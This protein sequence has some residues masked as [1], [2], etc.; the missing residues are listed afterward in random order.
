MPTCPLVP[1]AINTLGGSLVVP[2]R[3]LAIVGLSARFGGAADAHQYW[4]NILAAR[5]S[6]STVPRSRWDHAT[7]FA[8]HD[9]R[10]VHH[11][12]SDQGSFI[13]DVER[14]AARHFRI[15]PSR[16]HAMD[17][18]HRLLLE[19]A[20]A[21]WIDAGFERRRIDRSSIGVFVGMAAN[22]YRELSSLRIRAH[23]LGDDSVHAEH[24]GPDLT[25]AMGARVAGVRPFHAFSM[26]GCLPNM[27]PALV[28]STLDLGGPSFAVDAACSSSL[29]ALHQAIA[30]IRSGQCSAALVG[31][32]NLSL[33]PD[34]M[35]AF[36]RIGA[37]SRS[38]V[39]RPFDGDADGFLLGEG[40]GM[41]VVKPLEAA[42]DDHD[43]VY[44]VI[45]GSGVSNDGR[46]EGPMT[47]T[48]DGQLAALRR[49]YEDAAADPADLGVVEA[50]GTATPVGDRT[51]L[52]SLAGLRRLGEPPKRTAT[53][54]AVKALVGHT[55]A[56]AGIAS[57]VKAALMARHRVV[58][59]QPSLRSEAHTEALRDGRL[60]LASRTID[61]G[62]DG[63][64][65]IGVSSFGF[66][67]TN[68]HV[69][70]ESPPTRA[71]RVRRRAAG[72]PA[73]ETLPHL[74]VFSAA[75]PTLLGE[76]LRA[77]LAVL[78]AADAPSI[79]GLART[80]GSR[81][82]AST[83]LAI[84]CR[85][86]AELVSGL[87]AAVEQL[88]DGV[89]GV[90]SADVCT[91]A[92]VDGATPR[93]AFVFP[94]Q[95]SQTPRMQSDLLDRFPA[96]RA[97]AETL[98]EQV[99]DET[100]VDVL[101]ALS[102]A[103]ADTPSGI[104]RLTSTEVCQPALAVTALATVALLREIGVEPDLVIGHSVGELPA[105]ATAV[106]LDAPAAVRLAAVRG[107]HMRSA[108]T[109]SGDGMTALGCDAEQAA[110]LL[111]GIDD[112]WIAAANDPRQT[113]VSGTGEALRTVAERCVE[114]GVSTQ[115][116]RVATGFHS[117]L[118]E[119]I[120]PAL[121]ADLSRFRPRAPQVQLVST[122]TGRTVETGEELGRQL[123]ENVFS[124]VRFR[125]AI[126]SASA[127]DVGV[128]VQIG[129]GSA[130]LGSIRRSLGDAPDVHVIPCSASSPDDAATFLRLL[131]RLTV[132]GADLDLASL[133]PPDTAGVALPIAPLPT[134]PYWVVRPDATD[135][136]TPREPTSEPH[137]PPSPVE[138]DPHSMHHDPRDLP[139]SPLAGRP[140]AGPSIQPGAADAQADHLPGL[141]ALMNRQLSLIEGSG[142]AGHA[143]AS[144]DPFRWSTEPGSPQA[145]VV[146]RMGLAASRSHRAESDAVIL[147]MVSR[148]SGFPLDL[149]RP[150]MHLVEQLGFDSLMMRELIT[151]LHTEWPSL[152]TPAQLGERFAGRPT[153][154]QV[155]DGVGSLLHPFAAEP[156]HRLPR[157]ETNPVAAAS[158]A[159]ADRPSRWTEADAR[160]ECFPEAV[161]M[162]ERRQQTDRNP[163]F[164]LHEGIIDAT[165]TIGDAQLVSFSS[166]NYLGVTGHPVVAETIADAVARYG[167]SV[168]ASRF[169]SGERPIH[170]EL[171]QELADLLQVESALTM[172]SGHATNVSVIGHLVEPGDLIV[173]DSLAHDSIIQGAKLSGATRRSFPHNDLRALD[174]L[175]G[176]IR[177]GFRRVLIVVEGVYSM[178]GDLVP[179]PQLIDLKRRHGAL[180]LVDE[181]HSIGTVG[182]TGGGVG[183]F[184]GVDRSDI[185]LWSGTMSKSLAGC[186]GYVGGT[187]AAIDYLKYSVPGFVYSVG[188]TPA[189]AAASLAALRL[190]RDEPERLSRLR[191]NA[192]R[193]RETARAA[194]IDIGDSADSPVV[195]CIV[196][197]SER[198]L[199]LATALFDHGFSVN[200]ILYP[201]VPDD[202]ARLR[203]FITAEHTAEQ[204]QRV[205]D[206]TASE[207]N[208]I[209]HDIEVSA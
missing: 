152:P 52:E 82:L 18:Q 44:A 95:G 143:P 200:P 197:S 158:P 113:V 110:A 179:L 59:G 100:G 166:Y 117:P 32:V 26:P 154:E 146:A 19:A 133:V 89:T 80:L 208:R 147:G 96:F 134:E 132:L 76:H 185:D 149:I 79:A 38:G 84:V 98:N 178:D 190:M 58:P 116:L 171:E 43:D 194:G 168:S 196:G 119:P 172:V 71:G 99:L 187:A 199:A 126:E 36:S 23:L 198:A 131:G 86:P 12:Y 77:V 114:H 55:M 162:R 193:F 2:N 4:R 69:V 108:A 144:T 130:L 105:M 75:D 66:G 37:L 22:D 49:A 159:P 48:T 33:V 157:V 21:A 78:E 112:A 31:G 25:A 174:E 65:L 39:C 62:D 102:A 111:S 184:F 207:L 13:D 97:A 203:F 92:R 85:T 169:L 45:H 205:V 57:V 63:L 50:H 167:S 20:R 60:A 54:T 160:I 195:P 27:G 107:H 67:G 104:E 10:A 40:V 47:P 101:A 186:G 188:I 170:A 8:P 109:R 140:S 11:A 156:Q 120:R 128:Y 161:A 163:Y 68:A 90:I 164:L 42:I 17:P 183:E 56:A 35:V 9:P 206:I 6:G 41:I 137:R 53:V 136:T 46:A 123:E 150:D 153:V 81:S 127:S 165:T 34:A 72:G 122:V 173:H 5:R 204:I 87:S 1:S 106:A 124:T 135:P 180:V 103:D 175:L 115:P 91:G 118:L 7:F 191:Q 125:D 28:S 155:L 14:F 3:P 142:Q 73:D 181:A 51:E 189:N 192:D 201:A 209:T 121:V 94:G 30:A 16:A 177:G 74:L 145:E 88:A 15:P 29:V 138:Q 148:I 93:I 129:G 70:L 139:S 202:Q 182:A 141:L 61:P 176:A 64:G 24:A 83:R 151:Q